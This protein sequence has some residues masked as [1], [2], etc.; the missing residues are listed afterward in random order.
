MKSN[1]K[2]K[3]TPKPAKQNKQHKTNPP[4]GILWGWDFAKRN[5]LKSEGPTMSVI[6]IWTKKRQDIFQLLYGT[7]G[8][9]KTLEI[10][11]NQ[12][13]YSQNSKSIKN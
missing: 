10:R 12:R 7:V 4:C 3:K 6:Q 1:N 2:F 13:L 8:Q 9:M 11:K 5:W